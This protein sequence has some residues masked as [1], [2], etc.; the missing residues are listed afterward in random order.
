VVR[1][2]V[3]AMLLAAAA[4]TGCGTRTS[5][6]AE[7]TPWESLRPGWSSL[8]PQPYATTSA[9]SVWTGRELFYWGGEANFGETLRAGGGLFDPGTRTWSLVP[10]GPLDAPRLSSGAVWTGS[11]VFVWG[12]W[13]EAARAWSDGALFEPASGKWRMLPPA[14]LT[15]RQPVAVVWT[16]EEVIVWGDASRSGSAG[17]RE[18]AAFD[19]AANRWRQLP[20]APLALNESNAVWTGKEMIVVGADLDKNN[21]SDSKHAQGIAYDPD[22]PRRS[23]SIFGVLSGERA[24]WECGCRLVLR[25]RCDL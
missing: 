6:A 21:W 1:A 8:A 3:F 9:V 11:D 18:G 10:S 12:G 17:Q 16:G 2:S 15:A 13:G 20:L 23:A 14:P 4:L 24:S 22:A 25:G 7:G 5:S 19:P